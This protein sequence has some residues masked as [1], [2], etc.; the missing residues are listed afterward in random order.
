MKCKGNSA[1]YVRINMPLERKECAN[2]PNYVGRESSHATLC[3]IDRH[4][5]C[6]IIDTTI[7]KPI[8][9]DRGARQNRQQAGQNPGSGRR[10]HAECGSREGSRSEVPGWRILRSAR[11]RAGQVRDVTPSIGR[12]HVRYQCNRGVRG[13]EADILPDQSQLRGSGNRRVGAQETGSA[14]TTQGARRGARFYPGATG[15]GRAGSSAPTGRADPKEIRS[16]CPPKNDRASS[17]GK[18]NR[19]LTRDGKEGSERMAGVALRYEALRNAALGHVLSPEA[20]SGLLLFL[21]RGMWGWARVLA[22]AGTSPPQPIRATSSSFPTAEESRTVIH[23]FAAM[24]MKT[25]RRGMTP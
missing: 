24:A 4:C 23:I 8:R 11:Y 7:G 22:T 20:R 19:A 3:V 5:I 1:A 13:L 21:R 9:G 16:R 12:E 10:G 17:C 6:G 15:R 25:E 18:K 2:Y 14:R